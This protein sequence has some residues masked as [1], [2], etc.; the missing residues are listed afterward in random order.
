M[1]HSLYRTFTTQ[2][3]IDA[4]YNAGASV[5]D[6]AA[7]RQH[8]TDQA[9]RAR[10]TLPCLLDVPYGPTLDE[11]LDIFPA[12]EPN[13]PV[14]VF[15]HGGYWR[16]LSSKDFSGVALGPRALG[17]TTVVVNY[18][19]CPVVTIDEIVR[20]VRASIAWVV[21]NIANHNGDPAR[22]VLGGHSAGGHLTAMML[23]TLWAE[24]YGLPANPIAA[25]VLVSGIYDLHPLRYS[26]LQPAIQL[27]DGVIQRNSP[28]L[29]VRANSTPLLMTW[30]AQESTEF[31]RQSTD[32]HNGWVASGGRSELL[33]QAGADHFSA[34]HGFE[35]AASPLCQ[36]MARAVG[37]VKSI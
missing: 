3:E 19:L 20:Q 33:A 7:C 25:A 4:Q 30:G 18:S 34:V 2:A 17:F 32:F 11:T 6:A 14:W 24:R 36:W 28:G 26:Y 9:M 10:A 31:A 29:N 5:P 16:A 12:A 21:R 15:I 27:D 8:Y 35:E 13:A 22:I 1:P 37:Q 23:Q